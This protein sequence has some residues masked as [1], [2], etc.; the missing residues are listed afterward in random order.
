M[1]RRRECRFIL[2][3]SLSGIICEPSRPQAPFG[4]LRFYEVWTLLEN[5]A[6]HPLIQQLCPAFRPQPCHQLVTVVKNFVASGPV[7]QIMHRSWND[8]F[9]HLCAFL[10]Y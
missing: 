8:P 10:N 4:I 3:L 9:S 5:P 6:T 7:S 2:T 1:Q